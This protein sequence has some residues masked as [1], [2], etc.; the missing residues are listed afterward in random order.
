[1]QYT[2]SKKTN[3]TKKRKILLIIGISLIGLLLLYDLSPFGGNIRFYATWVACG[4]R[5]VEGHE[6][7]SGREKYY[8][9]SA[10]FSPIRFGQPKY[11]C[12]PNEA[13]QAG[14]GDLNRM[15][16]DVYRSKFSN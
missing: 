2:K 10:S 3:M 6:D 15:S 12:T 7:F 16:D 1:M 5:P 11:F 8:W 13:E 4:Q 14:Y 9:E